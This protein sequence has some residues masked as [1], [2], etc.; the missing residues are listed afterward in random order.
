M[1]DG[2]KIEGVS[3]TAQTGGFEGNRTPASE[4]VEHLGARRPPLG[5]VLGR[6]CVSSFAGQT[7]GVGFK[8]VLLGFGDDLRVAW[9]F[10]EAFYELGGA[11]SG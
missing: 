4:H 5:D 9:V 10:A 1:C 11:C 7:L 3:L 6:D 8:D 2:V